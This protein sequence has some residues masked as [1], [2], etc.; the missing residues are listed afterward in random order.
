MSDEPIPL[1]WS[2]FWDSVTPEEWRELFRTSRLTGE[3]L[4]RYWRMSE[5]QGE[6]PEALL[7]EVYKPDV[8]RL[9]RRL[10]RERAHERRARGRDRR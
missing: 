5:W 8:E 10:K 9:A 6:M 1:K 2:P 4:A 3:T 7:I